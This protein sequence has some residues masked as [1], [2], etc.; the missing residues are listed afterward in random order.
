LHEKPEVLPSKGR[1]VEV[2]DGELHDVDP[3][4]GGGSIPLEA[5]RLDL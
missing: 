4:S 2:T 1:N 3:F 5:A